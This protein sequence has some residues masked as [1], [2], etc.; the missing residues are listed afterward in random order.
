M[1]QPVLI[2]GAGPV[3]MTLASELTRYGVGVRIVDKAPRRTD[4]SK[5]LV[6]WSRTLELLDRGMGAAPFVDAGFKVGGVTIVAGDK[7]VGR[8]AMDGVPSAY[9]FVLMIPQSETERL[10]EER[11]GEQGVTV[12]R[13]TEASA[14]AMGPDGVDAVL[15]RA[16]GREETVRARWLVG[17]DG[18]HSAVRHALGVPFAGETLA[19]DWVLADV[20]MTGY[21]RPDTDASVYWHRD[22]V[23]IIFPISP[24]RYRILGDLPFTDAKVPPAPS[25]EQ[26]QALIDRRGPAGTAVFDPIWLSGFRINGRKVAEY[27][28][29]RVFLAGDAAHIHSPAGGQ[30]MNTGMQ[31]AMNLAWKLALVVRGT[32]GEGLLD[33]YSPERSAV[34]DEVLKGAGRLTA[35]ATL[36]NPVAQGLRNL[37]GQVMLGLPRVTH[38]VADTMSEVAIHYPE[39]PLN[40]PGLHDGPKPGERVAPVA[41]QRPV[42]SGGA[43]LF[44]LFAA[45]GPETE[46]LTRRFGGRLLD[47][48]VRPPFR[49]DGIWLVRPDGYAAMAA[50][51]HGCGWGEVGDY[52]DRLSGRG[53]R[54]EQA[55]ST[56]GRRDAS[57]TIRMG[58]LEVRFLDDGRGTGGALD[59]FETTVQPKALT[60]VAH[61]HEAWDETVY[62]LSGVTTWRVDGRDIDVGP[63]RSVFI[64]RGVVHAFRNDSDAPATCLNVLTPGV[65]GP[66]YFREVAAL[67]AAGGAPDPAKLRETMLRHGLVPAPTACEGGRSP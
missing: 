14:F 59:L 6:L 39:S 22:G 9:A 15:R 1:T 58:G 53:V 29:G 11:L 33:S 51:A 42:G 64:P 2:I 27:R 24:G 18:A 54:V 50:A 28:R 20:H 17:C 3:G 41:G 23:L 66:A 31:D 65:L 60:P 5:A 56:E 38:A 35:V 52:L 30:G 48:E 25:L 36:K 7:V 63:G 45:C 13:E 67:M 47:P 19:S 55:P 4:K 16:D 49:A 26:I 43:P 61:Y 21:P 34:G 10:L 57:E 12:E 37:V 62:G 44:T 40:G 8:V 32:C 46:A